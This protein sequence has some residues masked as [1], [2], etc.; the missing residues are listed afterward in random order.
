MDITIYAIVILYIIFPGFLLNL[1]I[2]MNVQSI[3][4]QP[5]MDKMHRIITNILIYK[6]SLNYINSLKYI[7]YFKN[8]NQMY[9]L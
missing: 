3:S 6:L 1:G 7:E 2:L 8:K 9:E 4:E 5:A